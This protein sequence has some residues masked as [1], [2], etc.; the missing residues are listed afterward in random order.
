MQDKQ[1]SKGSEDSLLDDDCTSGFTE[2]LDAEMHA[3]PLPEEKG[4]SNVAEHYVSASGSTR[5]FTAM[6]YGK[7]Y[8]LKCLKQDYLFTPVYQQALTKEFEIGLQL[9]H[10]HI[11]R[12]FALERLAGMGSTIVMEYVDGDSLDTLIKENRLSA[13]L[14]DRIAEEMMDALEYMHSKQIMHRDIKPA[15]IMLT[16]TGRSVKIIDFGLSDSDLFGVL[17]MPAGTYRYIAPEQLLPG[18][19]AEPKADIY[20][21]GMVMEDMA[22]ATH[23]KRLKRMDGICTIKD[24]ELRPDSIA[25]LRKLIKKNEHERRILITLAIVVAALICAAGLSLALRQMN[26][27]VDRST[28]QSPIVQPSPTEDNQIIDYQLWKREKQGR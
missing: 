28:N 12:T 8:V 23:S 11:C 1:E 13:E 27:T 19:A 5:L 24:A 18:A 16:H 17:K 25:Q 10:P 4:F 2:K 22:N 26:P 14:A 21:L 20:S 3:D 9:E 7:R 6:K 15:N